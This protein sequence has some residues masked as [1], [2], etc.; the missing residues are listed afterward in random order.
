VAT[1]LAVSHLSLLLKE[2]FMSR[3]TDI[4]MVVVPG[5]SLE[6]IL[7]DITGEKGSWEVSFLELLILKSGVIK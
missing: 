4:I 3:N 1:N 7:G 5:A 6:A 2:L